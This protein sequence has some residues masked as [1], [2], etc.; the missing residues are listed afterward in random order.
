MQSLSELVEQAEAEISAAADLDALDAVRVAL[1]L[2]GGREPVAL[3]PLL[4]LVPLLRGDLAVVL[5]D[6]DRR[7]EACATHMVHGISSAPR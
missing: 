3:D 5:L 4:E 1:R 6:D 7:R 2:Y